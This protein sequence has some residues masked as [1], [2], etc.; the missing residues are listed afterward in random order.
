MLTY[1]KNFCLSKSVY[2]FLLLF[3]I[4]SGISISASQIAL[5]I[6][7]LCFII[8]A[9]KNK[10]KLSYTSLEKYIIPF[11]LVSVVLAFLSPQ[12]LKN[13]DYIRDF[14]LLSALILA[15][16]LHNSKEDIVKTLYFIIFI[17][18]FQSSLALVQEYYLNFSF[19]YAFR[20]GL[21]AAQLLGNDKG[22]FLGMHLVFSCYLV[23]IS[24]PLVYLSFIKHNNLN[25][26]FIW[27][28]R[29]SALLSIFVLLITKTKSILAGLP[30]A[31]VPLLFFK[32]RL[33][34][35]MVPALL[36][37]LSIFSLTDSK[38]T[39]KEN[40]KKNIVDTQSSNDRIKIWKTAFYV[41]LKH[42]VIGAGGGNYLD[43]FRAVLKEHPELDTGMVTHAHND[44]LNQLA[45][46]GIIGFAAFIYML[47]GIFK[48]MVVNIKYIHD[49]LLKGLYLG[50]FGA[51]C[52]FLVASLFQCFYTDDENLVMFWFNIGLL[53]SIVK[54]EKAN[55]ESNIVI[56]ESAA[57]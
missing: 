20:N 4:F 39:I 50:L 19:A 2:F 18:F 37:V 35:L 36:I 55:M 15:Y 12:I 44:Y 42:P 46:K 31:I 56:K 11:I 33:V 48:Y 47:F 17:A 27:F 53:A 16:F 29:I 26:I 5:G 52:V 49:K 54:V 22:S 7:I 38:N 51:Y 45:R 32:K 8:A 1:L 30:L 14:W 41:W 25:N 23:L 57:H 21:K 28:I 3:L 40:L 6:A 13:L 10:I 43:E 34:L 24:M 9:F